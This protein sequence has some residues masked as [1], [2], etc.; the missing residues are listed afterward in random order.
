MTATLAER[1]QQA[2]TDVQFNSAVT[3]DDVWS[4]L[5]F[6][7][8]DLHANVAAAITNRLREAN[9]G[10]KPIGVVLEGGRGVGK[11]HMLRWARQEVQRDAGH[12]FLVKFL[13]GTEFWHSVLHSVV[14]GFYA[15]QG[16]QLG[17]G[18][19]AALRANRAAAGC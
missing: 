11:T 9:R 12:F 7:V 10:R 13:E 1:R 2:L 18:P 17:P 5:A 16:D 15:G 4:P 3:P 19:A 14:S 8:T 6:H